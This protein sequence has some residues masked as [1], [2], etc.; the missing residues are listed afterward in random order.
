MHICET[1]QDTDTMPISQES[2]CISL[3][4]VKE[5]R[6]ERK[7]AFLTQKKVFRA[8]R[9]AGAVKKND[10]P[11]AS[12]FY[13]TISLSWYG[14]ALAE[15]PWVHLYSETKLSRLYHLHSLHTH[16]PPWRAPLAIPFCKINF[17][18]NKVTWYPLVRIK[19]RTKLQM[20]IQG[21]ALAF[22]LWFLLHSKFKTNR[23]A[24]AAPFLVRQQWE[25][26]LNS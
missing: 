7:P 8:L 9:H 15:E 16:T 19:L 13:T 3:H 12:G 25:C 5:A 11:D 17:T 21:S 18:Q 1:T 4:L 2:W 23:L 24:A 6:L 26:Q 14:E 10:S 22:S 20:W